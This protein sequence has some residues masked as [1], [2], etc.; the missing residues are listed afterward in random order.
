MRKSILWLTAFGMLLLQGTTKR[1]HCF[2]SV[3]DLIKYV[4]LSRLQW[5]LTLSAVIITKTYKVSL[6]EG[7]QTKRE[8][9]HLLTIQPRGMQGCFDSWVTTDPN[10]EMMNHHL[11]PSVRLLFNLQYTVLLLQCVCVCVSLWRRDDIWCY[12]N[13][14]E[15]NYCFVKESFTSKVNS[16]QYRFF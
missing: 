8:A 11:S 3:F 12:D 2:S 15:Q 16:V 7:E 4:W 6:G 13:T 5:E 14:Q 10:T 1:L 9:K